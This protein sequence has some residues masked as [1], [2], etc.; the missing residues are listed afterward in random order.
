MDRE[1]ARVDMDGTWFHFYNI[2]V[3]DGSDMIEEN[4]RAIFW[5]SH[6]NLQSLTF[7]GLLS[8]KCVVSGFFLAA[9]PNKKLKFE[10]EFIF[11]KFN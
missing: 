11:L 10:I 5:I 9:R 4:N 8:A 7:F 2:E 1:W 3:A 6:S